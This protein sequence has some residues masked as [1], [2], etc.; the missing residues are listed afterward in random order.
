MPCTV[1]FP[2]Q[3]GSVV[4]GENFTLFTIGNTYPGVPYLNEALCAAR[5]NRH[6]HPALLRVTQG[7]LDQ[8]Y[9]RLAHQ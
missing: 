5:A 7:I 4:G 9:Q 3:F 2:R 8:V 1:Y 6:Q